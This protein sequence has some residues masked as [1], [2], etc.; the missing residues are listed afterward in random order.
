MPLIVKVNPSLSAEFQIDPT[1]QVESPVYSPPF[2]EGT[3]PSETTA[4]IPR[5]HHRRFRREVERKLRQKLKMRRVP[6][7]CLILA[8]VFERFAYYGIVINFVLFLDTSFG[9]S[10]FRSVAAVFCFA[11][12]S[13]L[14]C[15]LGGL[16][17]DSRFGRYSTIVG[18]FAVY[19]I[20]T[21]L[22][23]LVAMWIDVRNNEKS[24]EKTSELPIVP[25]L[26]LVLLAIAAGE[27]AVKANL[28][29][30]GADQ[31]RREAHTPNA[32]TLFNCFFWLSNVA[33]VLFLAG[34]TYIQQTEW[35]YGFTVGYLLPASS[36]SVAVVMFVSCRK[37]FVIS[38]PRGTG[39]RNMWIIMRQAWARRGD[40]TE[41]RYVGEP[42]D[43]PGKRVG[44]GN[45]PLRGGG[46]GGGGEGRGYSVSHWIGV[47]R[48]H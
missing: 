16:I 6:V 1:E 25:W 20:G 45:L 21:F 46:G 3:P 12:V 39:L 13:W 28:S 30:F 26:V 34:L 7:L 32:K 4:L 47:C 29:A 14:M 10:L 38:G 24:A 33:S 9:W 5:S 11:C 37:H 42:W 35:H 48:W 18:G 43:H 27:G 41:S 40:Q 44:S 23:V 17:A 8:E 31:L 2:S 15:A 36:L 19:L 22:L